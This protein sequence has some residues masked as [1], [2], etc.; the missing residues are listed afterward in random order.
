MTVPIYYGT[1]VDDVGSCVDYL[2][3]ESHWRKSP[4]GVIEAPELELS[5][6]REKLI[7]GIETQDKEDALHALVAQVW[8][9]VEIACTLDRKK[10]YQ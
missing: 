4:K 7:T 8:C 10:R 5:G 6:T 3:T 9:D 2:I 1:G